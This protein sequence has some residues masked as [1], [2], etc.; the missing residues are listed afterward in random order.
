[1]GEAVIQVDGTEPGWYWVQGENGAT[2]L[3]VYQEGWKLYNPRFELDAMI[4][5]QPVH[6]VRVEIVGPRAR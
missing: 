2:Y 6:G 5:G 1:M 3:G 4:L